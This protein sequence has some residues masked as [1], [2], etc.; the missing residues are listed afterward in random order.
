MKLNKLFLSLCFVLFSFQA[1][2]ETWSCAYLFDGKA[3]N[4]IW[5]RQ[6]I[7]FYSPSTKST[8]KII[9][10]DDDIIHLHTTYSPISRSYFATLFDKK[11]KMFA[12]VV[13]EIGAHSR[14]IEGNCDIY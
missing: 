3:K 13:L 2:A 12:K 14:I 7:N 11:Q 6:G 5:I 4:A 1:G 9:F 8:G 10:E